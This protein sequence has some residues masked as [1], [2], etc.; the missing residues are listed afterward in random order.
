MT[1]ASFGINAIE[2]NTCKTDETIKVEVEAQACKN[3]GSHK[4][5]FAC[6]QGGENPCYEEENFSSSE[7]LTANGDQLVQSCPGCRRKRKHFA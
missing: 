6:G 3:D 2:A 4:G 7:Q 1:F 5:Q